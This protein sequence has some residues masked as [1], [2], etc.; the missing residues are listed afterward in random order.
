[1]NFKRIQFQRLSIGFSFLILYK[2]EANYYRISFGFAP[3]KRSF[4]SDIWSKFTNYNDN[5]D[6]VVRLIMDAHSATLNENDELIGFNSPIPDEIYNP[7]NQ[8]NRSLRGADETIEELRN[9]VG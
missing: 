3:V 2:K 5:N 1:M 8:D 6:I 9:I 4:F 7:R